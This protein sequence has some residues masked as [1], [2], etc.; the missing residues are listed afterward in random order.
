MDHGQPDPACS[1]PR[2]LAGLDRVIEAATDRAASLPNVA[3]LLLPRS[4]VE[5]LVAN[6]LKRVFEKHFGRTAGIS[7]DPISTSKA[8]GPYIRFVM[9]ALRELGI[10]NNGKPYKS[11]T[12]ARAITDVRTGRVRRTLRRKAQ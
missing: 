4:P 5:Y 10:T 3:V 6:E 11:E 1:F 2:F 7:R 12:I 9:A 8:G